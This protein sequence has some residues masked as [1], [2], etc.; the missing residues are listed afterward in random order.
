MPVGAIERNHLAIREAKFKGGRPAGLL[1][2]ALGHG[3]AVILAALDDM[4]FD[5]V[6][7]SA[8]RLQCQGFDENI[9]NARHRGTITQMGWLAAFVLLWLV[10]RALPGWL[11]ALA[12]LA[13]VWASAVLD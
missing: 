8:F 6:S 4:F 12:T 10:L 5:F 1:N 7:A 9:A 3:A 11:W 2:A 13:L